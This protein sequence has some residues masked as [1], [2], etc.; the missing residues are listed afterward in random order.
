[1]PKRQE[2][3][4]DGWQMQATCIFGCDCVPELRRCAVDYFTLAARLSGR[5]RRARF[6]QT[7]L[8]TR[9]RRPSG[10]RTHCRTQSK[11]L[12][13][14]IGP[15]GKG[16]T[17][18]PQAPWLPNSSRRASGCVRGMQHC[19]IHSELAES[20]DRYRQPPDNPMHPRLPPPL[21]LAAAGLNRVQLPLQLS[22][23]YGDK[24][25]RPYV[26]LDAEGKPVQDR[27]DAPHVN[28]ALLGEDRGGR[29]D[30]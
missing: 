26:V 11:P 10:R 29:A 1:M 30:T 21:A 16:K 2:R 19:I 3:V 18:S 6:E 15:Y 23:F 20:P 7:H 5:K 17:P 28:D 12:A 9:A 14:S 22:S 8:R 13:V 25:A 24:I 27:V 4:P